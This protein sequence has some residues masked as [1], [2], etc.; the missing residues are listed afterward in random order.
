M[1]LLRWFGRDT[2]FC[3]GVNDR[4]HYGMRDELLGSP[5]EA[6]GS[7]IAPVNFG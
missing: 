6:F 4:A 7:S 3:S 1:C 2:F 5:D